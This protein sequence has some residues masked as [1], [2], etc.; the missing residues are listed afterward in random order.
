MSSRA[1]P[2]YDTDSASGQDAESGYVSG[3]GSESSAPEVHFSKPHLNF[4]NRQLQN[5]E[6]QGS[7]SLHISSCQFWLTHT[8]SR[9]PT[10]VHYNSS[11]AISD[12]CFWSYRLSHSRYVVKAE[13]SEAPDG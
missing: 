11:V 7:L 1:S 12:D 13:N 5:L 4:L 6:P 9:D 2:G 10:M 8:P 3:S